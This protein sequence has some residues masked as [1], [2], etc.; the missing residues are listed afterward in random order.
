ML[1]GW[2]KIT[3]APWNKPANFVKFLRIWVYV[4]VRSGRSGWVLW[5]DV[6]CREEIRW[7]SARGTYW[8][9]WWLPICIGQTRCSR[10]TASPAFSSL[11]MCSACIIVLTQWVDTSK[12]IYMFVR[13][14]FGCEEG[15][16]AIDWRTFY[17]LLGFWWGLGETGVA[18]PI[19][20]R[21]SHATQRPLRNR[22]TQTNIW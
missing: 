20:L 19:L 6:G 14:Y 18:F 9:L 1:R 3:L 5:C 4:N 10:W 13:F 11:V 17:S 7:T 15:D 8:S 22:G 21:L 12:L 2:L 16:E